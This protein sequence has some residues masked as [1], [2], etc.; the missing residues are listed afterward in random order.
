MKDLQV[1][2]VEDIASQVDG[3][4]LTIHYSNFTQAA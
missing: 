4:L 3:C 1:F 2:P